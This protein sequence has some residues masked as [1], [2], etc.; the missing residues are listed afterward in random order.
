MLTDVCTRRD[1]STRLASLLAFVPIGHRIADTR[2][3]PE[4]DGLS[5]TAESIHQELTFN[6]TPHRIYEV[7]TDAGRFSAI[8]VFSTVPNAPPAQIAREVGGTFSLFGGHILGRHLALIPD[9]QVVQAWRVSDWEPGLY[10]IARFQLRAQG[11]KTTVLFDHTGFPT[12]Q[13]EHFAGVASGWHANY[14]EPL[15]KYLG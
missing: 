11:S 4:T 9:Q 14:W 5:R 6:A 10:S 12:G 1:F 7:L 3:S 15:R 13:G 2:L 8:T